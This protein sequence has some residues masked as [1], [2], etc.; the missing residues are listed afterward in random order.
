[1]KISVCQHCG[2]KTTENNKICPLCKNQTDRVEGNIPQ[3]NIN[4]PKSM[5]TDERDV[6][7]GYLCYKCRKVSKNQVCLQCNV[8]GQFC[9]EYNKKRANIKRIDSLDEVYNEEEITKILQQ[10]TEE[11]KHWIYHNFESSYQFFY[12]RDT[13]KAL[14]C[15]VM[16][17]IM[18]FIGL[19]IAR[20]YADGTLL[21]VSYFANAFGNGALS[22]FIVLSIWYLV[23][24]TNVEYKRV[25]GTVGI[26]TGVVMVVY[27]AISMMLSFSFSKAI[28]YGFLAIVLSL[29][30]NFVYFIIERTLK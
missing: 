8:V 2:F 23:D 14:V 15:L 19:S 13:S 11:E 21:I 9:I 20:N 25:A 10:L 1:M 22:I 5:P 29:L 18:Y 30:L 12:K 26:I 3:Y 24:A 27:V 7:I 6:K 17:L 28:I 16:G 4:L